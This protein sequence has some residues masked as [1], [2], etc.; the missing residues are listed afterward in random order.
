MSERVRERARYNESERGGEIQREIQQE[1]GGGRERYREI[2][3]ERERGRERDT[4][5]RGGRETARGGGGQ[6]DRQIDVQMT[7]AMQYFY[8]E[9]S[10]E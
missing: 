2:Q 10:F 6:S 8:F 1:R 9:N 4:M 5:M 7:Y 3:H